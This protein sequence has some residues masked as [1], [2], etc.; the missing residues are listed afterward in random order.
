MI[1]ISHLMHPPKLF[2][3][4]YPVTSF[5]NR[6]NLETPPKHRH[7]ELSQVRAL[8]FLNLLRALN[9]FDDFYTIVLLA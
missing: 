1:I 8:L 2:L 5:L 7:Q 6:L 9:V 3:P 4:E